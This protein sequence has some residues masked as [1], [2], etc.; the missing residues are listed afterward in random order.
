MK[1]KPNSVRLEQD[2]EPAVQ[3]WLEINNTEFADL[4]DMALRDYIFKKQTIELKP[5]SVDATLQSAAKMMKR[6]RKSVDDLK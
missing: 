6:H 2:L 4:V 5:V 1:G 3:Q